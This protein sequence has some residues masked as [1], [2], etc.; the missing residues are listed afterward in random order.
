M[1]FL[2][3]EKEVY[4]LT[5]LF[6]IYLSVQIFIYH[7]SSLLR[8]NVTQKI[9]AKVS[10]YGDIILPRDEA[11]IMAAADISGRGMFI[12]DFDIRARKVGDFDTE[13]VVD[14]F[15]AFAVNAGITLHVR[16][17]AGRNSHH[18][19]EGAFKA[20]ARALRKCIKIDEENKDVIPSTKG[21][22]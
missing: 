1:S 7:L 5:H 9:S 20:V 3:V 15:E 10:R 16:Q 2:S 6:I 8:C 13:L 22:L 4:G 12:Y 14:F 19:I 18:I 21:T 17:I 11:L